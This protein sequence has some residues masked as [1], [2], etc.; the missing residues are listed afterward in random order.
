ME[1]KQA[2]VAKVKSTENSLEAF[3]RESN[4]YDTKLKSCAALMEMTLDCIKKEQTHLAG[5]RDSSQKMEQNLCDLTQDNPP[6]DLEEALVFLQGMDKAT[7]VMQKWTADA[8][9]IMK[10]DQIFSLSK[11]CIICPFPE[12]QCDTSTYLMDTFMCCNENCRQ[13]NNIDMKTRMK[14]VYICRFSV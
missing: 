2:S 10:G 3:S 4:L 12:Y 6:S 14:K 11:V 9:T 7:S 1:M 8:S 5:L 13:E